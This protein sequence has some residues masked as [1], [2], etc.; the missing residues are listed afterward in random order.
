M[1]RT[2]ASMTA[3]MDEDIGKV[4]DHLRERGLDKN[5]LVIFLSDN[6]GSPG[7]QNTEEEP[8]AMNYS[9]NTPLRGFKGQ[10]YEGGIRIPY[11]AAWPGKITPGVTSDAAVSS[12][13]ILPTAL[14]V[15]EAA[16]SE[17]TD[18]V[19][20]LP[21]LTGASAAAPHEKLFWRFVTY[22]AVRKGALKLIKQRDKPDEV[23]DLAADLRETKNLAGEQ[24]EAVVELNK[25]L[26]ALGERDDS[27]ALEPEI[28]ARARRTPALSPPESGDAD[29]ESKMTRQRW[30]SK[31]TVRRARAR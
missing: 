5:T 14:A 20:L 18:G 1:R 15:A 10:C 19:N 2:L 28:P 11:M 13:D 9:L 21:L 29:A 22:K 3:A 12:L 27:A 31:A 16:P 24:P 6:G 30:R 8:G 26:A 23:Y 7:G 17:N 25:E 4:R